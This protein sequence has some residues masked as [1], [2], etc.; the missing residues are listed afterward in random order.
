MPRQILSLPS[1]LYAT[2]T[3]LGIV[4][5]DTAGTNAGE[6]IEEVDLKE[7]K[8]S[9]SHETAEAEW[10]ILDSHQQ[11]FS[12]S[13][14]RPANIT[15]RNLEVEVEAAAPFA[16]T[17]KTKFT[18]PKAADVEGGTVGSIRRKKILKDF[19]ADSPAGTLTA[20]IGG[21]GSGKVRG[22]HRTRE[23]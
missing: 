9:S 16:D 10:H 3:R 1:L 17:L 18:K 2:G 13:D 11:N 15:V 7:K 22:A 6:R 23:I 12:F 19:S 5:S 8:V 4:T 21:S 14:V 20:I